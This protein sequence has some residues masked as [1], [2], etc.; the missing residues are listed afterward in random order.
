M[1]HKPFVGRVSPDSWAAHNAPQ[2]P[3]WI[4]GTLERA[5]GEEKGTQSRGGRVEREKR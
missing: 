4:G 1:H 3:N 5:E 2:S